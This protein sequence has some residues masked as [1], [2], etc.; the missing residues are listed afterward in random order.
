VHTWELAAQVATAY[1]DR[2]VYLA[3][4]YAHVMPSA[5]GFGANSGIQDAH[6]LA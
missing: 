4:D 2:R 5:G 3:G 1:R 6:N